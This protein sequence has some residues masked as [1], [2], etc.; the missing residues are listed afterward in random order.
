MD[1]EKNDRIFVLDAF[2]PFVHKQKLENDGEN[3]LK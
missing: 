2:K 3:M 1:F